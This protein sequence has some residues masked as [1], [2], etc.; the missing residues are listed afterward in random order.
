MKLFS[1]HCNTN[2]I[3]VII[4]WILNIFIRLSI[5]SHYDEFFAISQQNVSQNEY[6]FLV[7]TA[8]SNVLSGFLVLYIKC[9]MKQESE[10]QKK[11]KIKL[12]YKNPLNKRDKYFYLNLILISFIDLLH[13]SCYCIFYWMVDTSNEEIS[14]KTEKDI[15]TLLDII[16]RYLLSIFVL[17][18]KVYKHHIWSILAIIIGFV[19]I[20]PIDIVKIVFVGNEKDKK[21]SFY[22]IGIMS[23]RALFF[24]LEHTLIKKFY[25]NYYI[26]PENL[27]FFMGIIQCILLGILTPI[28]IST[29]VFNDDLNY[30][31]LKIF[32]SIIYTLISFVKQTITLKIIYLFS[33]QSVSFLIISTALAGS[34]KDII[35]F[36]KKSDKSSINI[37]NY[38]SFFFG[39]IAF[40]II[41]FGT[42]VYDEIL[43]INKWGLNFNVK[44]GIYERSLS[45]IDMT[46][47]DVEEDDKHLDKN[48][49]R[50][51]DLLSNNDI[52]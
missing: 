27:L 40:I 11:N 45:E 38:L 12:I 30:D 20:V 9:V 10:V 22:Y 33:S 17:K 51:T 24:P 13:F 48:Y 49:G 46:L 18:I 8:I 41:I 31:P 39:I 6:I 34:I 37:I 14:T 52:N 32:M 28:F 35:D 44:K 19:L 5:Y 4:Y 16:I 50:D 15:K 25:S 3:Y 43:I 42:L 2:L 23:L 36:F 29:K 47:E 21:D 26:L 1:F 7:Y